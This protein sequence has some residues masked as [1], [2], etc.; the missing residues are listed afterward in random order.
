MQ[1][2]HRPKL[3]ILGSWRIYFLVC[4]VMCFP[5]PAAGQGSTV[6]GAVYRETAQGPFGVPDVPV[7]ISCAQTKTNPSF[8]DVSGHYS[9][10]NVPPGPCTLEIWVSGL[11][12]P[13]AY[14]SITVNPGPETPINP[15]PIP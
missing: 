7:T 12:L 14:Y 10:S 15:I 1:S 2:T 6:F 3:S 13:P 8:T 9:I 11:E 5:H 4:L